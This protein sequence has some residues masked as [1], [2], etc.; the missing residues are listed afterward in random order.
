MLPAGCAPRVMCQLLTNLPER[1]RPSDQIH[2]TAE[3]LHCE[4]RRSP[5][6]APKTVPPSAAGL[7]EPCLLDGSPVDLR[8][9]VCRGR[10]AFVSRRRPCSSCQWDTHTTI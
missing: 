5:A 1:S 2:G 8:A 10:I 4:V 6:W 9:P 3:L 7:A